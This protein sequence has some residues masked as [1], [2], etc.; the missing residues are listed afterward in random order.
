MK[1]KG[2]SH[3]NEHHHDYLWWLEMNA[4]PEYF[5]YWRV[6]ITQVTIIIVLLF[7]YCMPAL[8]LIGLFALL[9]QY[10][11]DRYRIAYFYRAP[12]QFN[13]EL[14]LQLLQYMSLAST[15]GLGMLFW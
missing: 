7:G 2:Y 3:D 5:F 9:L 13:T 8:Y 10:I 12:P 11:L 1:N 4:G 6:A 14:T 15:I